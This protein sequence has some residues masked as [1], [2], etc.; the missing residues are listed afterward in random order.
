MAA[1][2]AREDTQRVADLAAYSGALAYS[3]T[4]TT[5]A[6]N[7]AVNRIATLN[8]IATAM[9]SLP[10][11]TSPSG[12]GNQAVQVTVT[13]SVP[14][15]LS[16]VLA[17]REPANCHRERIRRARVERRRQRV[18]HRAQHRRERRDA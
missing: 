2:L 18:H 12:D 4:H 9:V 10:V 13:T 17:F 3:A 1:L 11:V 5:A 15:A 7:A 16:R 8:G 6:L 14:L